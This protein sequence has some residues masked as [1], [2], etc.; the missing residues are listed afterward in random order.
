ML[1]G[2]KGLAELT[3]QYAKLTGAGIPTTMDTLTKEVDVMGSNHVMNGHDK[4]TRKVNLMKISESQGVD[5][6]QDKEK[7][8]CL[9]NQVKMTI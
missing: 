2:Y 4:S 7:M 8:I 5:N 3:N 6:S 9:N 1:S